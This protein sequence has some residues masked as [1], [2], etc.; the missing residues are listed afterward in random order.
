MNKDILKPIIRTCIII[1]AIFGLYL[2]IFVDGLHKLNFYTIWSNIAVMIFYIYC[3]TRKE[4]SEGL[5]RIKGGV[6]LGIT[7]TFIVY[8]VLLLPVA[9]PENVYTW[10]NY[11]L[12]YIVPVLCI[13]D[14]LIYDKVRYKWQDPLYWT[15][16][17]LFYAIF[18]LIKGIIYPVNIPGE[19]SPFPYFFVDINKLGVSGIAKY[20][21]VICIFYIIMGYIL[22]FIKKIGLRK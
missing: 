18:T 5:L 6:V 17:P 2:Q 9:K 19:D 11:T 13:L 4:D 15:I 12:H 7:L 3:M 1:A 16:F 20:I 22:L 14:C 21:V 10:K 8:N